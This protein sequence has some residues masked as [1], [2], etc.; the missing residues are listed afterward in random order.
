VGG[1]A[2][3]A[4]RAITG[5]QETAE[6]VVAVAVGRARSGVVFAVAFVSPV[7]VLRGSVVVTNVDNGSLALFSTIHEI[8]SG[9]FVPVRGSGG[10]ISGG[11]SLGEHRDGSC[12]GEE[13]PLEGNHDEACAGA[14][15]GVRSI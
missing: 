7:R 11:R 10:I 8:V 2:Y 15:L 3:L 5:I 4:V 12:G 13:E 6:A 1:G 9:S 14:G